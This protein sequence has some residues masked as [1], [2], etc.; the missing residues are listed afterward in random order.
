MRSLTKSSHGSLVASQTR[1]VRRVNV[2]NVGEHVENAMFTTYPHENKCLVNVVNIVRKYF[3]ARARQLPN[4]LFSVP[5]SALSVVERGVS[6][7]RD[8][9]LVHRRSAISGDC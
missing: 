1:G 2:V 3:D 8:L 6:V 9:L 7:A 4:Q 5:P